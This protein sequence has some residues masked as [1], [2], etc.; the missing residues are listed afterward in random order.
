MIVWIR[1]WRLGRNIRVVQILALYGME[2]LILEILMYSLIQTLKT[3]I[4][5]DF[6]IPML[7]ILGS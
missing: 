7:E 6:R 2:M 5:R 3:K 4:D 1:V